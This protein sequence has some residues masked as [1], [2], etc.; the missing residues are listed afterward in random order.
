MQSLYD[1]IH[2]TMFLV[3]CLVTL[4]VIHG[5][6]TQ[7]PSDVK[8]TWKSLTDPYKIECL[9][10][11]TINLLRF[12]LMAEHAYVTNVRPFGCYLKCI[13]QKIG[14]LKTD[15]E[16]DFDAIL[17]KASYMSESLTQKCIDEAKDENDGCLKSLI[18]A[19]CVVNAL[20]IP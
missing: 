6:C 5:A 8:N 19:K 14:V 11:S 3:L 10:D 1:N 18:G 7:F 17:S 13:Y 16:F 20:S 12:E 9:G 15:G 4:F 2:A